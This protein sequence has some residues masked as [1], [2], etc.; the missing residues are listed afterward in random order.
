MKKKLKY[1]CLLLILFLIAGLDPRLQATTY[2]YTSEK[3]PESFDGFRIVQ[4]SDFHLKEFGGHEDKLIQAVKNCEPDLI[5]FTG[6]TVDEDHDDITPLAD[7]LS[8]IDGLAPVYYI[9]GNHDLDPGAYQLYGQMEDLFEKHGAVF[10]DDRRETVSRN[11]DSIVLTGSRW[12]SR[13]F[14]TYLDNAEKDAFNILFYHG[15]NYFPALSNYGY[16]LILA[17]HLHGGVIRIPGVGG[18]LNND[19]A[20]FP[21][22]DAGC[23]QLGDSTMISSR[24]LGDTPIPRFFNR[25]ELVCVVLH[26]KAD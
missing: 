21:E 17:G 2:H 11:G 22:Y 6:D 3:V 10:L 14:T 26:T 23:F 13:Y 16:D 1:L 24:G 8:G 15:S 18:L 12:R 9:T 25:P 5:V 7:L 4:L 19:G 20:L